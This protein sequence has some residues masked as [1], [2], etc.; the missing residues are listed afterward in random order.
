MP[1]PPVPVV[2]RHI[3]PIVVLVSPAIGH[4]SISPPPSPPVG[5][6]HSSP[7]LNV[8]VGHT[9]NPPVP[10]PVFPNN[11][12]CPNAFLT[13]LSG[14]PSSPPTGEPSLISKNDFIA[15]FLSIPFVSILIVY[16]PTFVFC[17]MLKLQRKLLCIPSTRIGNPQPSPVVAIKF[18]S[19]SNLPIIDP[20]TLPS[21]ALS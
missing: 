4:G 16:S 12:H 14:Q 5:V 19:R 6:I 2:G 15:F 17:N 13:Y 18:P 3:P 8:P 9:R 1:I 7:D 20:L 21:V 10:V 11:S